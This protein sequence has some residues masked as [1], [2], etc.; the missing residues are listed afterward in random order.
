MTNSLV[1]QIEML[2]INENG[3]IELFDRPLILRDYPFPFQYK[4]YLDLKE[5]KKEIAKIFSRNKQMDFEFG[6]K[7]IKYF[8]NR[9]ALYDEVHAKYYPM[10]SSIRDSELSPFVKMQLTRLIDLELNRLYPYSK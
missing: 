6:P 10:I 4:L 1:V 7:L 3:T 9:Q 5:N 8:E 2:C